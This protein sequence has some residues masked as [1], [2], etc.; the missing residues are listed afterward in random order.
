MDSSEETLQKNDNNPSTMGAKSNE[1]AQVRLNKI[2]LGK[3]AH[4]PVYFVNPGSWPKEIKLHPDINGMIANS[5]TNSLNREFIPPCLKERLEKDVKFDRI[6]PENIMEDQRNRLISAAE[7]LRL[8]LE[9]TKIVQIAEQVEESGVGREG[10]STVVEAI[11]QMEVR[12]ERLDMQARDP[13]ADELVLSKSRRICPELFPELSD[14]TA[15]ESIDYVLSY[16]SENSGCERFYREFQ[17]K[18]PLTK[19]SPFNDGGTPMIP[20]LMVAMREQG[21]DSVAAHYQ[22]AL[23]TVASVYHQI[24]FNQSIMGPKFKERGF[25]YIPVPFLT[26]IGHNWNVHWMYQEETGKSV[27][28]GSGVMGAT[29]SL[30]EAVKLVS[31]LQN[32][33]YMLGFVY[34]MYV[35]SVFGVENRDCCIM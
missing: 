3:L 15:T 16:N 17:A 14:R 25:S 34:W 27:V 30:L 1:G 2:E 12:N 6:H 28:I 21:G 11:L 9:V 19:L 23:A 4:R 35:H 29:S 20:A 13:F 31:N 32:L 18:H 7:A 24:T 8:Y 5:S 26:V 33:R 22:C 10:W